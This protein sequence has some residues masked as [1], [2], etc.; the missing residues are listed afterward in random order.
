M[1]I[2]KHCHALYDESLLRNNDGFYYCPNKRCSPVDLLQVDDPLAD[3]LPKIWEKGIETLYSCSGHLYEETFQCYVAF[4]DTELSEAEALVK[5]FNMFTPK[6]KRLEFSEV[7]KH[8][9]EGETRFVLMVKAETTDAGVQER[10]ECQNELLLFLYEIPVKV[11][12]AI[13]YGEK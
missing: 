2:C 11:D 9:V 5:F 10:L 3:I 12:E 13:E 1:Y 4:S 7:E 6:Y 8:E